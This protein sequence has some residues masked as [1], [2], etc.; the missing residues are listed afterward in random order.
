MMCYDVSSWDWPRP[1]HLTEGQLSSSESG[2]KNSWKGP[3]PRAKSSWLEL[4][5]IA[6]MNRLSPR[7]AA[8]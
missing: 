7:A 2:R 8:A 5:I 6:K 1:A 4:W 3:G